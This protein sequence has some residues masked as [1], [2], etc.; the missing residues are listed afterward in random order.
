MLTNKLII[1]RGKLQWFLKQKM[2]PHQFGLSVAVGALLG[3]FP[4]LG[5][6]TLLCFVV[7]F[8]FRLNLLWIQLINYAVYP[9]QLSLAP[10]F[11]FAGSWLMGEPLSIE[12]S[13]AILGLFTEDIGNGMRK[14]GNLVIYAIGVWLVISPLMALTIYGLARH[15]KRRIGDQ[16]VKNAVL[17]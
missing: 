5:L 12:N 9:L 8:L 1:I 17:P 15:V 10:L 2:S 14:V 7:A 6:S 4:V 16:P 3:I 11:I 13:R